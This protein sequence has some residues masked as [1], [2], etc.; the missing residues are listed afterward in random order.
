MS[1]V[2]SAV[3]APEKDRWWLVGLSM[4]CQQVMFLQLLTMTSTL[5]APGAAVVI[6]WLMSWTMPLA[7]LHPVSGQTYLKSC[8][9]IGWWYVLAGLVAAISGV[10]FVAFQYGDL[11]GT[12]LN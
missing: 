12:K 1:T 6:I 5:K 9:K 7:Y 2:M 10:I 3:R 11:F 4:L 8:A